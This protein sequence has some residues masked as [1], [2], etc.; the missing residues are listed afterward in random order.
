MSR[1]RGDAAAELQPTA[2]RRG[3]STSTASLTLSKE[4]TMPKAAKRN[5]TPR[6]T[7]SSP[8]SV[9]PIFAA[10]DNHRK[11]DKATCD[12]VRADA[13]EGDI[14]RTGDAAERAAWR[15][16]RTKPG[17][18]AGAAA[19]LAYITTGPITGLFT[20]GET[21]WHETAFRNVAAALAE[22]ARQAV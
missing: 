13:P 1:H 2:A 12:L 5:S 3:D 22:I 11:L 18:A 17:T 19:L 8:S 15:M 10:L 20:L 14:K 4:L 16:A 6:R 7:A 21:Y 9:D